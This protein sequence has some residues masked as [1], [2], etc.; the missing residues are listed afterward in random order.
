MCLL[1]M[2]S[3]CVCTRAR[4][5]RKGGS[6]EKRQTP[7]HH[8]GP[9]SVGLAVSGDRMVGK[10]HLIWKMPTKTFPK[11]IL[12][13]TV[14]YSWRPGSD[15]LLPTGTGTAAPSDEHTFPCMKHRPA[16]AMRRKREPDRRAQAGLRYSE[17]EAAEPH[18]GAEAPGHRS[19]VFS[20]RLSGRRWNRRPGRQIFSRC[21]PCR[22][23]GWW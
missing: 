17:H 16:R 19:Y 6:F 15:I 12:S 11:E 21:S 13:A 20:P 4:K 23:G 8:P 1:R 7:H 18:V 2:P 14:K 9:T 10:F 22:W 5:G 3:A